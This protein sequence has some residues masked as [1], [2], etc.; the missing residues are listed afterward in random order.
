MVK[1]VRVFSDLGS[2]QIEL[3]VPLAATLEG[4]ASRG[5]HRGRVEPTPLGP[6]LTRPCQ[7]GGDG[8]LQPEQDARR[9]TVGVRAI[10]SSC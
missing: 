8:E 1:R 9:V 6:L 2:A 10:S 7:H 3:P 5:E 4:R